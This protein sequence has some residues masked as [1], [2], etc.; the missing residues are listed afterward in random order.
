ML[1]NLSLITKLKNFSL[2]VVATLALAGCATPQAKYMEV[3]SNVIPVYPSEYQSF[4]V[5]EVSVGKTPGSTFV[6]VSFDK[7]ALAIALKKNFENYNLLASQ[8]GSGSYDIDL[9]MAFEAEGVGDL[10]VR[11][12]GLYEIKNVKTGSSLTVEVDESYTAEL[13]SE[14]VWS[15]LGRAVAGAALGA[16]VGNQ[17]G[18]TRSMSVGAVVGAT[19]AM[20]R[21]DV[22]FEPV[23]LTAADKEALRRS[24][25]A[26][27]GIPVTA[28]DGLLRMEHA[29]EGSIRL[30]IAMFME[31]LSSLKLP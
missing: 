24:G 18:G 30:N 27:D 14:M 20:G 10:V 3:R 11:G 1:D 29:Y 2:L 16:L 23:E 5:G 15:G 8:L 9:N 19:A 12:I 17:V 4:S 7:E 25:Y 31:K 6:P 28:R 26:P 21:G 22:K 13:T